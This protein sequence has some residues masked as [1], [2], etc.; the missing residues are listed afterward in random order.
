MSGTSKPGAWHDVRLL[1][2]VG[3]AATGLALALAASGEREETSA[4]LISKRLVIDLPDW[5]KVVVLLALGLAA[6]LVFG[7]LVRA[8]RKK[9]EEDREHSYDKL[10]WRGYVFLILL[11]AAPFALA[12]GVLW[13]SHRLME[14]AELAGQA[15]AGVT[16]PSFRSQ[17][18]VPVSA[19]GISALLGTMA[20]V[21][22][23]SILGFMLWLYSGDWLLARSGGS[24]PPMMGG[25]NKA[26]AESL[27]D[28]LLERDPRRA[29][30]KC[31]SRFEGVLAAALLARAPWQTPME[32]MR[33]VLQQCP[34]P[35]LAI[36][37]LTRLFEL[38][39][40]SEHPLEVRER[41]AAMNALKSIHQ[42]LHR[43]EGLH[44]SNT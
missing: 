15:S 42:A 35:Q 39:R 21:I 8:P 18:S 24:L 28:V 11:A 36:W 40:F 14:S 10:T 5:L 7:M 16:T 43:R 2:A 34:V 12:G 30:I 27:D 38:A 23:G 37:E 17:D 25:L 22:A 26:V 41:E 19:P 9:D 20:M 44:E 1:A 4:Q 29:I 32:F 6:L 33:S 31:Y 3:V 13:L